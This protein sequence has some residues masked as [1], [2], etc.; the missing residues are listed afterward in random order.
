MR[1]FLPFLII[2]LA[3]MA[4]GCIALFAK[5]LIKEASKED[6]ADKD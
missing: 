1:S 4:T 6:K 2:I 3:L 5:E